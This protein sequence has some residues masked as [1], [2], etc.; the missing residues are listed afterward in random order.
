MKLLAFGASSSRHSINKKLATY[1]ANFLPY[2]E[3]KVIDLNDFEMPLYSIDKEKEIGIPQEAKEFIAALE[4]SDIIIISISEHNGTYTAA[5]KNIFDWSSRHKLKMF[6][7]KK[8]YL[9]ST[10]MGARGGQT[11][12]EIA[13]ERFPRHGG[14]IIG[15]FSLPSFRDNFDEILGITELEFLEKFKHIFSASSNS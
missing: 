2:Q 4:W 15:S 9:L 8:I 10:S 7:G 11:A 6:E 5:F 3:L 14:E 1:A 12:L 13:M